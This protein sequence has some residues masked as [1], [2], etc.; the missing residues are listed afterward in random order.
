[1][2][3]KQLQKVKTRLFGEETK[4]HTRPSAEPKGKNEGNKPIGYAKTTASVRDTA[5]VFHR[6][7]IHLARRIATERYELHVATYL[8]MALRQTG[9]DGFISQLG[10]I[11]FPA[12][13]AQENIF[14]P[15][16]VMGGEE[17]GGIGV[18]Q[19][20]RPRDDAFFQVIGIRALLQHLHIVVRFENQAMSLLQ[21]T[22][23]AVGNTAQVG[24]KHKT[25]PARLDAV[26]DIIGP[27]VR[28]FKSGNGKIAYRKRNIFENGTAYR[29]YLLRHAI[30]T[31]H[32]VENR[33]RR[34]HG[35]AALLSHV[36]GSFDVVGM[37]VGDTQA[38]NR[39]KSNAVGRQRLFYLPCRYARIDK[40]AVTVGT[41]IVTIPAAAA[42]QTHKPYIIHLFFP[43]L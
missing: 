20:T 16:M 30:T 28:H 42:R 35:N 39:F 23:H 8:Y 34:V 41:Q 18:A 22:G 38:D 27:V 10:R 14:E 26:A 15:A 19:M 11:V 3:T 13:V 24:G 6:K 17:I 43:F 12:E 29:V 7:N 9:L 21:V 37:V 1:M 36:T 5:P 33:L 4:N 40:N 31:V 25:T 2:I 32:T